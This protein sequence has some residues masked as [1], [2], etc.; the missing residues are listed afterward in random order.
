VQHSSSK[1]NI[2]SG[3]EIPLAST[4]VVLAGI[5]A[6]DFSLRVADARA[7]AESRKRQTR[8][9]LQWLQTLWDDAAKFEAIVASG[10]YLKLCALM[11][12]ASESDESATRRLEHLANTAMAI[13][14]W[15]FARAR[16]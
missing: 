16:L 6:T 10:R 13:P 11:E 12:W 4:A 9:R 5:P 8:R 7:E 15:K 3:Q 14:Q 1:I 2:G